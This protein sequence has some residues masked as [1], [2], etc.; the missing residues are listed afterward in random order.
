MCP[1][2]RSCDE[3]LAGWG[4]Q[5]PGNTW[6]PECLREG[7]VTSGRLK[8]VVHQNLAEHGASGPNVFPLQRDRHFVA[9]VN[10][11][12]KEGAGEL[13]KYVLRE[14]AQRLRPDLEAAVKR[15]EA[16]PG[17]D[18]SPTFS[19]YARRCLKNKALALLGELGDPEITSDLLSRFRRAANMTDKV[20][21]SSRTIPSLST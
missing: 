20:S 16:P 15:C 5:V 18:F 12:C 4:P 3:R 13:R 11:W 19:Q 8:S 9:C 14:L 1:L 2:M 21:S 17:E 10:A 6:C 7:W